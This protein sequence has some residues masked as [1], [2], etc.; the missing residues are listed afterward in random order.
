ML[1]FRMVS[2]SSFPQTERHVQQHALMGMD[3][4]VALF[5]VRTWFEQRSYQAADLTGLRFLPGPFRSI[6][7][8][9]KEVAWCG[10]FHDEI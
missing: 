4:Y 8:G 10:K 3:G 6:V 2:A 1:R 5:L 9:A 7:V